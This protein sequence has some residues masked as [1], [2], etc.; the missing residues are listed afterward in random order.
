MN[1]TAS[2]WNRM[3]ARYARAAIG[4]QEAYEKKLAITRSYFTPEMQ[5][6]EIGC[7]TGSTAI[8]HAPHVKHIRATDISENMLMI[9]REK[10]AAAGVANITFEC[11]SVDELVVAEGTLDMV[12]ALSILHLLP[13]HEQVISR[14]F[15][16]LKPGGL[17][18]S[19][20]VCLQDGYGYLKY[21]LPV[22]RCVGFAPPTVAFLTA[23]QLE[24]E[25][26]T[27]GFII[28]HNWRPCS[29]KAVF[30]VLKKPE[31]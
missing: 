22:M 16:M 4:D 20:T 10:A 21:I 7:G 15:A 2:F 28:E 11:T 9:A 30:M 12:L 8:I 19:S 6:L 27:A 14:A 13:N 23:A 1:K 18:V 3:A 5:V 29:Q 31:V 17:L 25:F 24:H 26:K